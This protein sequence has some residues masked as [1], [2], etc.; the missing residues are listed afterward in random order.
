VSEAIANPRIAA[1]SPSGIRA[2]HDRKR[3]TSIDLSIGQP[4]LKP[5]A[6][7]F[8]AAAEWIRDHGCGYPPY[9]GFPELRE[10][11]AAVYGGP[12]HNSAA[13]VLVT[14]GSQEA[15]YLTIK[16]LLRPGVDETLVI[17]PGYPSYSRCCDMEGVAWRTVPAHARDGFRV[18]AEQI[19]EAL[20]PATRLVALGS[21]AN[22][23]GAI[24]AQRDAELLARE[25][26]NRP[27]P[28]VHVLVDEVY[29]ELTYAG[30]PFVSLADKYPHTI[31][32]QSLSKACALTGLRLGFLIGPES[33]VSFATRAHMLMLMSISVPAQRVALEI[34][35]RPELLKEHRPWYVSQREKMMEAAQAN[36]VPI[37]EPEGAF[38]TM[39]PL[40]QRWANDSLGAAASLLEEFDVV[41]VAGSVFGD[42][43]EGYLRVTWVAE[44]ATMREGY[45]RL[46]AFLRKHSS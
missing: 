4:S 26:T 25:L 40:P 1:L 46:G 6:Q 7:P 10:A 17:N 44:E 23:S 20:G 42:R 45:S 39:V 38:Y 31:V 22:P 37:I 24:F 43:A 9:Q 33:V 32:V 15:I 11:V 28:P 16:T 27:G 29:R 13:N 12:F 3:P 34:L 30:E 18:T 19:L 14:N 2:L 8:V 36:G 21:P 5:D 35:Q 41:T